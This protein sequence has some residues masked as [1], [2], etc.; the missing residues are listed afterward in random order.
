MSKVE[1]VL[2]FFVDNKFGLCLED[3]KMNEICLKSIDLMRSMDFG[4]DLKKNY[5]KEAAIY[6]IK[7]FW[8]IGTDQVVEEYLIKTS[9][10]NILLVLREMENCQ[11]KKKHLV[12]K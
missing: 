12:N 6:I 9:L 8:Q 7:L 3:D 11:E 2:K 10:F 1:D 4:N 5:L